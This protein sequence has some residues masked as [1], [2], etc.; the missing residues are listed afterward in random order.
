MVVMPAPRLGATMR[1]VTATMDVEFGQ[2]DE[3]SITRLFDLALDLLCVAGT[4]GYFKR[5]NDAFERVLGYSRQELLAIPFVDFVHPEDV[6]ATLCAIKQLEDGEVV[7]DFENRFR[8]KSGEWRWLVWRSMPSD[9]GRYIYA[10]A[11]D[12]TNEKHTIAIADERGAIMARQSMDLERVG[13]VHRTMSQAVADGATTVDVLRAVA[14]LTGK[15]TALFSAAFKVLH[16]VA[17]GAGVSSPG[18]WTIETAAPRVRR[19]LAMVDGS[20]PST[21]LPAMPELGVN[22][23]HLIGRVVARGEDIGY[24]LIAEVGTMLLVV[25]RAGRRAQLDRAQPR[26]RLEPASNWKPRARPARTS[27]LTCC[28]ETVSRP[29]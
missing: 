10:C 14:D 7:T 28:R 27:S 11:R 12:I 23:R 24:L 16:C 17:P 25:R 15:P 22:V 1:T 18:D 6:D 4:D 20:R 8:T 5:V 2:P 26:A 13:L 21:V 19:A 29:G 9:D 3:L